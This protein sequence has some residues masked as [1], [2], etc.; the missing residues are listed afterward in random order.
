MSDKENTFE[1]KNQTGEELETKQVENTEKAAIVDSSA[2]GDQEQAENKAA[3]EPVSNGGVMKLVPWIIT[4]V[5]VVALIAV[6]FMDPTGSKEVVATVNGDKITR[7]EL[8][9]YMTS[10]AG[11]QVLSNMINERLIDQEAKKAGITVTDAAVDAEVAKMTESYSQDQ[12]D[13]NLA[14]AGMTMSDLKTQLRT[15]LKI[16]GILEPTIT[17]TDDDMKQRYD[18]DK[19]YY[20]TPEQVKASHIL[21]DKQE[22]AEAIL[23]DLKGG[24]DFATLAKEKSKDGSASQGGDLGYFGHGDMVEEFDEAAFKLNVGEIS[25]VVKSKFGYHIIKVT[26]KKPATEPT[27]EE[28]KDEI[29][30]QLIDEKLNEDVP[31]WIQKIQAEAKIDNKLEAKAT[32]TPAP[33]TPAPSPEADKK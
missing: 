16:R 22:D 33:A 10:K 27:F 29:R 9:E 3:V 31:A 23:K 11:E 4:A 25:D 19:D 26:D 32:P 8:N 18:E 2:K 7:Q 6:L 15:E 20:K 13:Y 21:V 12:L 1:N 24:A 30:Q 5:A 17:I 14:Q 28:K